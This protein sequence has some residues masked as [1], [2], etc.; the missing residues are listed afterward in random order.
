M[1]TTKKRAE[2]KKEHMSIRLW[3]EFVRIECR[4]LLLLWLLLL[5]LCTWIYIHGND[6]MSTGERT[7]IYIYVTKGHWILPQ[8]WAVHSVNCAVE[9]GCRQ[10]IRIKKKR[11]IGKLF[12]IIYFVYHFDSVN[13]NNNEIKSEMLWHYIFYFL[14]L[15]FFFIQCK[16]P[17]KISGSVCP[18][19]CWFDATSVENG[20]D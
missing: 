20:S 18:V 9:F 15:C 6:D 10:E 16:G 1:T 12:K 14:L 2:Y 13:L 3:F 7:S 5:L 17:G 11:N 19:M 8:R 4:S